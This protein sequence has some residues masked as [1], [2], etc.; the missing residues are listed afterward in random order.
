MERPLAPTPLSGPNARITERLGPST[1]HVTEDYEEESRWQRRK[2]RE[3]KEKERKKNQEDATNTEVLPKQKEKG[4]KKK[5]K[6]ETK[7][8]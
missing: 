7:K 1:Q 8:M 5:E 3:E 6:V 4:K 2:E